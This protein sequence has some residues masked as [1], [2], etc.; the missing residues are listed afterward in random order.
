MSVETVAVNDGTTRLFKQDECGYAY[1]E[2]VFKRELKGLYIVT[3]CKFQIGRTIYKSL[4][5]RTVSRLFR[6]E[7][8]LHENLE[9]GLR[10]KGGY[11]MKQHR[12]YFNIPLTFNYNPKHIHADSCCLE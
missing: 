11:S 5:L 6:Y 9:L 1:R 10:F 2:S 12:F 3:Y 8:L 7:E 4:S